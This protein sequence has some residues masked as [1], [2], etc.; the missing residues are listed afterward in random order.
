[1]LKEL[2]LWLSERCPTSLFVLK[3]VDE[4]EP[5]FLVIE[6]R[7]LLFYFSLSTLFCALVRYT[8]VD[9]YYFNYFKSNITVDKNDNLCVEIIFSLASQ[10]LP[11]Y[12][13]KK[14]FMLF[15]LFLFIV[16]NIF[17][18]EKLIDVVT[19]RRTQRCQK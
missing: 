16:H 5:G 17:I 18:L 2:R 12:T 3:Y 7:C 13:L 14:I 11:I 9:Y 10:E 4:T 19:S 15:A 1:M 6:M 8:N